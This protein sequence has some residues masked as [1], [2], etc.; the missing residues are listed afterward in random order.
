MTIDHLAIFTSSTLVREMAWSVRP[1]NSVVRVPTF[2]AQY[3]A[4]K[5]RSQC[6]RT[7][8][9]ILIGLRDSRFTSMP[10]MV[11]E[12]RLLLVVIE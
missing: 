4:L 7:P 5:T 1:A 6:Q 2:S 10:G 11:I 3:E 8:R 12:V 9:L